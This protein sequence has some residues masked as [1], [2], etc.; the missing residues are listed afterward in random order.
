MFIYPTFGNVCSELVGMK[1]Y[2]PI[3][4][5]STLTS[6]STSISH[7]ARTMGGHQSYIYSLPRAVLLVD[8]N[9]PQP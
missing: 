9:S 4:G 7:S 1:T 8:R 6:N 2:S 3:L 5:L